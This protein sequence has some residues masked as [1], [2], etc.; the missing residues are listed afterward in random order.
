MEASEVLSIF[1]TFIWKIQLMF[2]I[3]PRVNS[4]ILQVINQI[5]PELAE[6]PL[7]ASWQSGQGLH[8]REQ[9]VDLISCIENTAQTV[10]RS[11]KV[12][13]NEIETT[14]CWANC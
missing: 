5:K 4:N 6:I 3:R 2:E 8:D 13:H 12:G 10:L 9:L 1:P 7:G 14:D 11:L